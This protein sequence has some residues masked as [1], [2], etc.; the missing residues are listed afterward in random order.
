MNEYEQLFANY[1]AEMRDSMSR[2]LT[3]WEEMI[4]LEAARVGS[5]DEVL[6]SIR[7]RWPFGPASH[8]YIIATYRKYFLACELLNEQLRRNARQQAVT[9]VDSDFASDGWGIDDG[10][11]VFR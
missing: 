9:R 10:L 8:P 5:I 2:A 1:V 3:W 11:D 4:A 6:S 7:R